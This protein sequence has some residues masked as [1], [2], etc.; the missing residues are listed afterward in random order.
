MRPVP[1]AVFDW[2][3]VSALPRKSTCPHL[4]PRISLARIPVFK[5]SITTE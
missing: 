2:P 5:A 3:T 4:R 1:A